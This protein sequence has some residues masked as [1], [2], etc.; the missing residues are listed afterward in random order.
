MDTAAVMKR[1]AKLNTAD[2]LTLMHIGPDHRAG[3]GPAHPSSLQ[4]D[5]IE[6]KRLPRRTS[7]SYLSAIQLAELI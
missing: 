5:C 1:I 6:T 7:E 4:M 2:A 3:A